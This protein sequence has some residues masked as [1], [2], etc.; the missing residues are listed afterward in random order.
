MTVHALLLFLHVVSVV[1]WVGGMFFA[2]VCLRPVAAQLLEPPQR[3]RL[4]SGVFARFFVWVWWA[5]ALIAGSGLTLFAQA[6]FKGSPLGWHLMLASGLLMI[7]IYIYVAS[8]PYRRLCCAVAAEDWPA[9][10]AAL[11]RIRQMVGVNL[12]LG[13]LTIASATFGRYLA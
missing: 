12:L 9:G 5:V 1:V 2:Y 6:G 4:W 13:V 8:V 10:G 11:N 7:A 3:L